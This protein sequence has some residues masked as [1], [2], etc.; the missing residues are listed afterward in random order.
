MSLYERALCAFAYKPVD[1]IL[2]GAPRFIANDMLD[3]FKID[4][5]VRGS[6]T[7]ESDQERFAVAKKRGILR[8]VDS[9]STVTTKSIVDRI[10]KTRFSSSYSETHGSMQMRSDVFD[11]NCFTKY[12]VEQQG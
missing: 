10:I 12:L 3:R 7:P 2:L 9:G 6:V 11:S 4:V 8:T 5:V 1:E